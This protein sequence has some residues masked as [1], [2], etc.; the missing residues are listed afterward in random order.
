MFNQL[1]E[2]QMFH[3]PKKNQAPPT[4]ANRK[5]HLLPKVFMLLQEQ[6]CSSVVHPRPAFVRPKIQQ[7]R[8][9]VRIVNSRNFCFIQSTDM[10]YAKHSLHLLPL[11]TV[12]HLSHTTYSMSFRTD[13]NRFSLSR[14]AKKFAL[15][16][17][18]SCV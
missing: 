11:R 1:H 10:S 9:S 15:V 5:Q 8:T 2:I 7:N 3:L 16:L 12:P 4:K 13:P 17:W 6:F 14:I 18:N